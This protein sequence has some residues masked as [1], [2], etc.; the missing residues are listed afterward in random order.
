MELLHCEKLRKQKK[1]LEKAEMELVCTEKI[2]EKKKEKDL[3]Q[4]LFLI[5]QGEY[6]FSA[7]I[8]SGKLAEVVYKDA[9]EKING[10]QLFFSLEAFSKIYY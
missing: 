8:L 1:E 2:L 4:I 9:T 10:G 7:E 5:I 6:E 3:T